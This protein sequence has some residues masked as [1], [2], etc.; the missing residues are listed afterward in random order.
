MYVCV[1]VCV[2]A[3]VCVC[4]C[5]CVVCVC[6]CLCVHVCNALWICIT[7]NHSTPQT[8][9]LRLWYKCLFSFI[10]VPFNSLWSII[11]TATMCSRGESHTVSLA[12]QSTLFQ[13][14]NHHILADIP[15]QYSFT[16]RRLTYLG[17]K[18]NMERLPIYVSMYV[19]VKINFAIHK[20]LY[21][22]KAIQVR[23]QHGQTLNIHYIKKNLVSSK[24]SSFMISLSC[25]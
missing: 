18:K 24:L 23:H 19:T 16:K 13:W 4:V 12:A 20:F 2:C 8:K 14:G 1:T 22:D 3:L 5:A 25:W 9:H 10:P 7:F 21:I 11:K 15:P 6:M 17:R